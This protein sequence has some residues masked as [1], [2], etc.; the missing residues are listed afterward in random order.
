M[1][2]V[3]V[4]HMF[5]I[6]NVVVPVTGRHVGAWCE[7][8]EQRWGFKCHRRPGHSARHAAIYQADTTTGRRGAVAAVWGEDEHAEARRR[9][10]ERLVASLRESIE[11]ERQELRD[12]ATRQGGAA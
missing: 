2:T 6:T 10:H 1:S 7:D 4:N 11:A 12:L 5:P 3:V 8:R 9:G